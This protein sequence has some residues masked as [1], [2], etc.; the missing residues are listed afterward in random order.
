M[1]SHLPNVT[2]YNVTFTARGVLTP[3]SPP[4]LSR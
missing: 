4:W 3:P 1:T 2:K